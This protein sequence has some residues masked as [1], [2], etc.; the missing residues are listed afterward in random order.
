[1]LVVENLSPD[2]EVYIQA[3]DIVKGGRQDRV[4][5]Y[6]LIVPP[7]SGKVPLAAFCVEAGRR[8]PRGGGEGPQVYGMARADRGLEGASAAS[9]PARR[10][11]WPS[12]LLASRDRSGK[13]SRS[14]RTSSAGG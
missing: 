1:E 12:A 9:P 2:V 7:R 4:L 3:G 5:S 8:Q 13:R 10:C 11:A 6:D 14:N